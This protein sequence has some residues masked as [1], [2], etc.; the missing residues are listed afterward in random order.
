MTIN[1]RYFQKVGLL[2]IFIFLE[3]FQLSRYSVMATCHLKNVFTNRKNGI[4]VY[5]VICE[6]VEDG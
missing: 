2:V 4:S 1:S 6:K 3:I 5:N